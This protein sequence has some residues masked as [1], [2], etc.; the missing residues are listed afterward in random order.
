MG[1]LQFL[2]LPLL[3]HRESHV[4]GELLGLV[5]AVPRL[6]MHRL[7]LVQSLVLLLERRLESLQ[8]DELVVE[9]LRLLVRLRRA[10]P[11]VLHGL[12]V[13][14]SVGEPDPRGSIAVVAFELSL[15]LIS[16]LDPA[17]VELRVELGVM[18]LHARAILAS[19]VARPQ[20]LL[21]AYLLDP[22]GA[23]LCHGTSRDDIALRLGEHV[24]IA[25]VN[26][27]GRRIGQAPS[28]QREKFSGRNL[29]G[30]ARVGARTTRRIGWWMPSPRGS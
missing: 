8:R 30:G 26:L 12:S 19:L 27:R 7:Q 14:G 24:R 6:E 4:L 22:L 2:L 16:G 13:R 28:G 10:H 21:L 5:P 23:G 11:L 18:I 9:L 20:P 25:L 1:A 17:V 3:L 29:G 15:L